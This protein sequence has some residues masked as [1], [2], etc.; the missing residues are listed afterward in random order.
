MRGPVREGSR[1]EGSVLNGTLIVRIGEDF[2]K[3]LG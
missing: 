3:E 1:R 2:T